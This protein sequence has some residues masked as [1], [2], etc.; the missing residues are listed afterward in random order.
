MHF[1]TSCS[2]FTVSISFLLPL[3]AEIV[4]LSSLPSSISSSSF[5]YFLCLLQSHVIGLGPVFYLRCP[6]LPPVFVSQ[7]VPSSPSSSSSHNHSPPHPHPSP[8][9][10]QEQQRG[11]GR[12]FACRWR[13]GSQEWKIMGLC[14]WWF[15]VCFLCFLLPCLCRCL[16]R[17]FHSSFRVSSNNIWR[18]PPLS[19]LLPFP[20]F[21]PLLSCLSSPLIYLTLLSSLLSSL[22]LSPFSLSQSV[23][24]SMPRCLSFFVILFLFV[25][26]NVS[27]TKSYGCL[28]LL[29]ILY[30]ID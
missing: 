24:V 22:P 1:F 18:S 3:W 7:P 9:C 14:V 26:L 20:S 29:F 25:L 21:S 17:F 15:S 23:C 12:V 27:V 2:V 5:S 19:P 6:R 30:P 16:C 11:W 8:Q 4:F 10:L 28:C 13:S